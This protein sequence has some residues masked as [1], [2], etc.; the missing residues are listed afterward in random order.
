[1]SNGVQ[2]G[3]Q[4]WHSW[5][6]PRRLLS[7]HWWGH[8][9]GTNP[10]F[11]SRKSSYLSPGHLFKVHGYSLQNTAGQQLQSHIICGAA[12]LIC[13]TVQTCWEQDDATETD[14]GFPN[15]VSS[16]K[17]TY[18]WLFSENSVSVF[19][20]GCYQWQ[21]VDWG[22]HVFHLHGLWVQQPQ[23]GTG[24]TVDLVGHTGQRLDSQSLGLLHSLMRVFSLWDRSDI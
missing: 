10:G 8:M 15:V 16:P 21:Q 4:Y 13:F 9:F 5:V 3:V 23:H 22:L 11:R 14:S 6:A 7:W 24:Q 12:R 18:D 20:W 17:P 2:G 19:Q 1:M